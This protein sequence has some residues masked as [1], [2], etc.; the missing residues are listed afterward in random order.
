LEFRAHQWD[1][2]VGKYPLGVVSVER[3]E[4]AMAYGLKQA[5]MFC[6][7]AAGVHTSMSE[8]RRGRGKRRWRV[9]VEE[10]NGREGD[11]NER[12]NE[13][14]NEE[15][16]NERDGEE[17]NFWGGASDDDFVLEGGEDDD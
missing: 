7:I 5:V 16:E 12:G 15:D 4:G 14:D 10:W 3:A 8:I 11:T 13:T 1:E 6:R 9:P 2:R 17:D